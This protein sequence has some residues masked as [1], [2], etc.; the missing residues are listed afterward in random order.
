LFVDFFF[1]FIILHLLCWK[2]GFVIFPIYFLLGYPIL[3]I[4]VAGLSC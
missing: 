1:G 2:L 3:I 4:Q